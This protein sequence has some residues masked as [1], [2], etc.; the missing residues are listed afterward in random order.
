M[1]KSF[2]NSSFIGIVG[3]N[4]KGTRLGPLTAQQNKASL[5]VGFD[6][7]TGKVN[8]MVDVPLDAIHHIGGAALVTT[9]YAADTLSFVDTRDHAQRVPNHGYVSPIESIFQYRKVIEASGAVAIGIVPGDA[10]ISGDA[11]AGLLEH[12]EHMGVA[13]AMLATRHLA[14]NDVVPVNKQGVVTPIDGE[15]NEII[16]HLGVH[17]FDREWLLKRMDE[18]GAGPMHNVDIWDS[19][20]RINNPITDVA[21]Y[22]SPDD[23]GWVDMGTPS[24]L[25]ETIYDS[26][27][28]QVDVHGNIAFPGAH[29]TTGSTQT[30][31]LPG[32]TGLSDFRGVIIPEGVS[33]RTLDDVVLL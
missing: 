4:G 2:E 26:N 29:L 5:P 6:S 3:V 10:R 11:L 12:R 14:G 1:M 18:V 23:R 33:A 22:V 20:Y 30:I 21:L 25:Q 32:S 7:A 8:R 19:I 13:A 27:R 15:F 16:A 24:H 9:H 31:A 17:V 28:D